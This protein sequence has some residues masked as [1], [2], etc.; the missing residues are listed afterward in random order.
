MQLSHS[1]KDSPVRA[2]LP[3][4]SRLTL[5]IL[6]AQQYERAVR[7]F[8]VSGDIGKCAEG[9]ISVA[10]VSPESLGPRPTVTHRKGTTTRAQVT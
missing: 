8:I 6:R 5:F 2:N 9:L 1:Q 3:N 7:V 4:R 10:S